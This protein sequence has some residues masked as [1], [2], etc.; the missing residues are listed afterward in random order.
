MRVSERV[1]VPGG[2][3]YY[4]PMDEPLIQSTDGLAILDR[5]PCQYLAPEQR[6]PHVEVGGAESG[7]LARIHDAVRAGTLSETAAGAI[8][9][10]YAES[11]FPARY[12]RVV[13]VLYAPGLKRILVSRGGRRRRPTLSEV[14]AP[15]FRHP[16]FPHLAAAPYRLQMDF[17]VEPPA[18]LDY[19]NVGMSRRGERHF[20]IGIDGLMLRGE[21][22]RLHIYLPG[23]A[24]VRS[25]MGMAQLRALLERN[26]GKRYLAGATF[27]RFRSESYISHGG[28][29]LRLYRGHPLVGPI[30]REKLAKA[31]ELAIDHIQRTQDEQGRFLYYYDAATDSRRD[32]EHPTR[33]PKRNPF[34]NI[35]RHGG[36]GLTCAYFEKWSR[37]GKTLENIRGAIDFLLA[38]ARH[39]TYAGRD[40]A[41]IYHEKKAKLGGSGIALYLLAEYQLLSGDTRY[42]E[43][44]DKLAW[45]LLHQITATGEFIYYNIYLDRPVD[46]EK[47]RD[48]FSFY[49]PGE[50]VCGLAKYLKLLDEGT[51][52]PYFEGLRRALHY[53]IEVRP[54]ERAEHYAALPSDAW[55]MMGV[56]ELWDFAP[57]RD[58]RYAD[59]V[60][61]DAAKMIDHQ[62]K[63]SD[64]P[65]PDYAGGFYYNWGDYPYADGARCEG[66][67]GAY[68][69]ALKMGEVTKAREIWRALK[70]ASW[71]LL[72]LVNSEESIY[73]AR[74]PELALGGIR[75]KQTRQWFRID[76]IQHVA[77]FYA[78]MLPHWERADAEE[79][80]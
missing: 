33:D 43:W 46:E 31:V 18:P 41:Y 6:M 34:Y 22:R 79:H 64:A 28:E 38:Q 53:L 42:R 54:T 35:L 15:L 13:L 29:W 58:A 61:S 68:E 19:H 47:N 51:R 2:L 60:F 63:V 27:E 44:A 21:D 8:D 4:P 62:Y 48:H 45:H 70:L 74:N 66:L 24:Y 30:T 56:M 78:K 36:G 39:Q 1:T 25:F 59:F 11:L 32:H 3:G 26:H 20:E 65:Y 23:D 40:G 73:F 16:R 49:Y 76:T 69:L 57:M 9:A 77:S 12:D 10:A 55:L 67:L 75:F 37:R 72:Q 52:E 71:A 17:V 80:P 14:L 7:L 5:D 50:A